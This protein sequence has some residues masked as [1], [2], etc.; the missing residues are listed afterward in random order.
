MSVRAWI[1]WAAA[2]FALIV[3]VRLLRSRHATPPVL[4][5]MSGSCAT[6]L[7]TS[8][9][10]A[11]WNGPHDGKRTC[12]TLGGTWRDVACPADAASA[13]GT[14]IVD[15]DAV[16]RRLYYGSA[17]AAAFRGSTRAQHHCATLGGTFSR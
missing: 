11:E 7:G 9:Q 14:C 5:P 16:Q 10:C 6:G 17:W 12:Q 8:A 1:P 13:G 3:G 15:K 4:R 2:A